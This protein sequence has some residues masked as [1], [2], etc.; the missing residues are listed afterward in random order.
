MLNPIF[1]LLTSK[2]TLTWVKPGWWI[3]WGHVRLLVSAPTFIN[4]S[5]DVANRK[6]IL[7]LENPK[8]VF[9]DVSQS[10]CYRCRI[11]TEDFSQTCRFWQE[12]STL[13]EWKPYL[14]KLPSGNVK[15]RLPFEVQVCLNTL[16]RIHLFFW[17]HL[18]P[19]FMTFGPFDLQTPDLFDERYCS[20]L[21]R[22]KVFIACAGV[23]Q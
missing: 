20:E 17:L 5:K 15:I 16:V 18:I 3:V 2:I 11:L 7:V 10:I 12:T 13:L 19:L 21:L 14:L 9:K 23:R 8:L 22:Q 6:N 1:N 4:K